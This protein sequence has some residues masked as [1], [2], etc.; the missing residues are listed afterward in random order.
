MGFGVPRAGD[1]AER[2]V[3]NHRQPQFRLILARQQL[4]PVST[5]M[6]CAGSPVPALRF[7][8]GGGCC[9]GAG[10]PYTPEPVGRWDLRSPSAQTRWLRRKAAVASPSIVIFFISLPFNLVVFMSRY[11]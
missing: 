1:G 7:G 5:Q 3:T 6:L 11:P 9:G 4:C 2:L 8:S 10:G